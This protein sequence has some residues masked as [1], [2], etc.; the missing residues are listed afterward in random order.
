MELAPRA[1]QRALS[2]NPT[3]SHCQEGAS[4]R[5]RAVLSHS[6]AFGARSH[7]GRDPSLEHARAEV[8]AA[9]SLRYA[10]TV[11]EKEVPVT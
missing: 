3:G 4:R 1:L 9:R 11:G 2:A 7:E 8:A 5:M 10:K 6:L